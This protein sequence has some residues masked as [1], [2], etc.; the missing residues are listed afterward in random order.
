MTAATESVSGWLGAFEATLGSGDVDR[1][2]AMFAD[3]CYWRDLVSFTWNI[4]TLEGRQEIADML[5]STLDD[6]QPSDFTSSARRRRPTGSPT[7]G[8][9]SRQRWPADM[10]TSGSGGTSA[11]PC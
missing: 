8:S 5:R 2:A 4:K 9:T 10:A 7:G 11:G 6:V 1:V 3:E